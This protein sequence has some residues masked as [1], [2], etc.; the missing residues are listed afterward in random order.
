MPTKK[1]EICGEEVQNLGFKK[2]MATHSESD[3]ESK[4]EN[5]VV[6]PSMKSPEDKDPAEIDPEI[7]S[8]MRQALAAEE[9]MLEAPELFFEEDSSD[10]HSA[11]VKV[12][13]P[14]TLVDNPE[15]MAVFGDAKKRLDGYA[16]KAYRPVFDEKG[17]MVKDEDGNPLFTVR[18]EI[19]DGRKRVFQKE[20]ERRLRSVTEEA[21]KQTPHA[22]VREEELTIEKN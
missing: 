18:K 19:Y 8:L 4:K 9:K 2:H 15:Y 1:C 11:L 17:N 14:E 5:V 10:Q 16:A 13:C 20:S 3:V 12:H 6:K 7:A 22:G 21:K